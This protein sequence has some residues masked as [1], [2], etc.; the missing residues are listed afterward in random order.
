MET[1]VKK[2]IDFDFYGKKQNQER[3]DL[4]KSRTEKYL[5]FKKMGL[6]ACGSV[7]LIALAGF[8]GK[9]VYDN[10]QASTDKAIAEKELIIKSVPKTQIIEL[11]ER[12]RDV[13]KSNYAKNQIL[14]NGYANYKELV[15]TLSLNSSVAS[16]N[17]ANKK[18][19]KDILTLLDA[20]QK[21]IDKVVFATSASRS[22]KKEVFLTGSD[23]EKYAKWVNNVQNKQFMYAGGIISLNKDLNKELKFLDDTQKDIVQTVKDKSSSSSKIK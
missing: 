12:E 4:L 22:V 10:A 19:E 21:S 14:I 18:L 23:M 17:N 15:Q 7:L 5:H 1:S 13:V 20:D 2:E 3:K 6:I 11:I 9:A 16:K 8:S